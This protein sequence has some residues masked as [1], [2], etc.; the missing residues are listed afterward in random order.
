MFPSFVENPQDCRFEGQDAQEKILLL[1]RAHP[2]TNFKWIIPAL[3]LFFLPFLIKEVL[4]F[5]SIPVD[6]IPQSF[7][8]VFLLFNFLLIMA[9][10]LEGFLY[11]YF[12]VYMVTDKNI[13]DVDFHSILYKNID[14]APLR[15]IEDTSSSMSG[16]LHSFFHYGN[17]YV[18]TAGAARNIDFISVPRP[19]QVAD[20]I[21]DET[22]KIHNTHRGGHIPGN[23]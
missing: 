23:V 20:F 21:L 1:L 13:I 2:I 15:N 22:H 8:L 7:A 16:L 19:H 9:I 5:V 14:V 6:I 4:I 18:Q 3:L 12:N 11:W 17:V 10:A